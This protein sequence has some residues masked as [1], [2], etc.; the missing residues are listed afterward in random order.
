[1][2]Q[3]KSY[4]TNWNSVRFTCCCGVGFGPLPHVIYHLNV[5]ILRIGVYNFDDTDNMEYEN[6]STNIWTDVKEFRLKLPI[7]KLN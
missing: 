2:D 5:A 3:I 4:L 6:I 7:I 1:M